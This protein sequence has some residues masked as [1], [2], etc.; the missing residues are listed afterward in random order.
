MGL[1]NLTKIS[2]NNHGNFVFSLFEK[3][4]KNKKRVKGLFYERIRKGSM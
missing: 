3:T 4:V 2:G 1:E